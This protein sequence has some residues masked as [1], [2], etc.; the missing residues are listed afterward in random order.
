MADPTSSTPKACKFFR[1]SRAKR[2]PAQPRS[3]AALG[4][5]LFPGSFV[6]NFWRAN[7]GNFSRVPKPMQWFKVTL[8]DDGIAAL[9]GIALQD[10]FTEIF[11]ALAG[12][13][14]AAM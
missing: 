4:K 3:S 6:G 11:T 9:K 8:S 12:P 10:A 1:S 7:L 14:D 2:P 13:R 5:A